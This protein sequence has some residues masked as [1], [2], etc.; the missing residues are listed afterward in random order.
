M[1]KDVDPDI[2]MHYDVPLSMARYWWGDPFFRPTHPKLFAAL[3]E[4]SEGAPKIDLL[5][6]KDTKDV[7]DPLFWLVGEVK[8]FAMY[9]G[10]TLRDVKWEAGIAKDLRRMYVLKRRGLARE[11]CFFAVQT[12]EQKKAR[13]Y[14][15]ITR[16]F[17]NRIEVHTIE[18]PDQ[19]VIEH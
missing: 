10:S 1:Q 12:E 11:S 8:Y 16:K 6:Y 18:V 4:I 15:R 9:G 14:E 7:P 13:T 3:N 2:R 17:K 5:A 19:L